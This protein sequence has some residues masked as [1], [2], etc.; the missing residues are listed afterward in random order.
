ML[1]GNEYVTAIG[2]VPTEDLVLLYAMAS[3]FVF[4]SLYEGFG[5]PIIE[6]MQLGCPVIT[7][8]DGSLSEVAGEAAMFVDPYDVQSIEKKL[9]MLFNDTHLQKRLSE[10]G[11]IQAK[12]F[13]W[14]IVA[15]ETSTVYEKII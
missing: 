1:K 8:K 11:I 12:K 10:K 14:E 3:V 6:A 4:P 13:S 2:F 15:R 9:K 5:L 7:S